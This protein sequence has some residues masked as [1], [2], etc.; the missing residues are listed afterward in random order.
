MRKEKFDTR[1]TS[2]ENVEKATNVIAREL[3]EPRMDWRRIEAF[4]DAND[5]R[6]AIIVVSRRFYKRKAGTALGL[7]QLRNR[8]L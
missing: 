2:E 3:D 8:L 1:T 5:S 6:Q 4:D 7:C